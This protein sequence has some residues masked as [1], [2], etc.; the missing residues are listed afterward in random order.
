[1]TNQLHDFCVNCNAYLG[2]DNV[3]SCPNCGQ[4]PTEHQLN[5]VNTKYQAPYSFSCGVVDDKSSFS[6]GV[7]DNEPQR[8]YL[9][10]AYEEI[11][12][13]FKIC[14]VSFG[15]LGV[16]YFASTV[17]VFVLKI[18]LSFVLGVLSFSALA[19][20]SL[21]VIYFFCLLINKIAKVLR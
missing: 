15:V 13:F 2:P 9:K 21:A 11:S 19:F 20:G 8:A 18:L 12:S 3:N 14:L 17:L 16:L 4:A 5:Y 10:Y 6:C 1:M 7:V